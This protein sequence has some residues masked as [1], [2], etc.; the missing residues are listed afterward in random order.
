MGTSHRSPTATMRRGVAQTCASSSSACVVFIII[1]AAAAEDAVASTPCS[2]PPADGPGG[3]LVSDKALPSDLAVL[4]PSTEMLEGIE[5]L[6]ARL[7]EGEAPFAL[8]R[9]WQGAAVSPDDVNPTALAAVRGYVERGGLLVVMGG[10]D[11][12]WLLNALFGWELVTYHPDDWW[13]ALAFNVSD[14]CFDMEEI[15]VLNREDE[16]HYAEPTKLSS[17]PPEARSIYSS[18]DSHVAVAQVGAGRV[19]WFADLHP[20]PYTLH[21]KP[22]T[23]NPKP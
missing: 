11:T 15:P 19:V 3:L 23:L 12:S 16:S 13:R 5:A 6:A 9:M 20:A 21:P 4:L 22:Y 10:T 18:A 17:L 1:F 8:V 14:T 7:G 2:L